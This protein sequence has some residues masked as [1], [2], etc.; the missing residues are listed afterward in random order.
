MA[1]FDPDAFQT[2]HNGRPKFPIFSCTIHVAG[3]AS[4][5]KWLVEF[6]EQQDIRQNP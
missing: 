1:K 4:M 2:G 3:D 6:Y 5:V